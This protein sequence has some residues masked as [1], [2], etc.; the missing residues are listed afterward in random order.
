MNGDKTIVVTGA[1]SG[2]GRET[3]H[4]LLDEG[5]RVLV[6]ARNEEKL[7]E[8]FAGNE[9]AV[10]LP[11][12]LSD[13]EQV[14]PYT[15]E[16]YDTVGPISGFVH[17]AAAGI[18]HLVSMIKPE[19]LQRHFDVNVYAAML[20]TAG[21][22]KKKMITENASFVLISSISAHAGTQGQSIYSA[23]KGALEGFIKGSAYELSQK[24]I[25]INAIAPGMVLTEP[26][27]KQMEKIDSEGIDNINKGY[28]FGLGEPRDI[29]NVI[30]F[31]F[32][33]KSRWITGQTIIV[34]GGFM[35]RKP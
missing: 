23:T 4:F 27:R 24:G 29:S 12:D 1:S 5:Y 34:D 6:T 7:K 32:S 31:L 26:I 2:I 25:R 35:I 19:L 11:W 3:A 22:A 16:V 18:N 8:D 10:I 17:C 21:F 9:N 33:D 15:K 13:V 14:I 28:P 30:E 20:L